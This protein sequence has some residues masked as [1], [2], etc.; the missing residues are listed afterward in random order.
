MVVV[1][2]VWQT[3]GKLRWRL[4]AD[5]VGGR[6]QGASHMLCHVQMQTH[7]YKLSHNHFVAY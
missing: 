3:L 4:W 6:S 5:I 7:T 2:G 1:V